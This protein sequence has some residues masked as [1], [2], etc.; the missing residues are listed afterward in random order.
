MAEVEACINCHGQGT[1]MV[2]TIGVDGKAKWERVKCP[3]GCQ[4][5]KVQKRII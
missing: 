3:A 2:E 1:V 4:N 5:G